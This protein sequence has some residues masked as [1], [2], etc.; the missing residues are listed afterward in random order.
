MR[1]VQI[2]TQ[3]TYVFNFGTLSFIESMLFPLSCKL[4][5]NISKFSFIFNEF[6]T[7]H[8]LTNQG[9]IFWEDS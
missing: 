6:D 8:H 2:E 5:M 1:T 3:A 4:N 9:H 7:K